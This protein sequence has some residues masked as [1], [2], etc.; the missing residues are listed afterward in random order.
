[1]EL[2]YNTS[3]KIAKRA[4]RLLSE[5]SINKTPLGKF[6]QFTL[7]IS[8][9]FITLSLLMLM[10]GA[11]KV[12]SAFPF[13]VVCL[14]VFICSIA[15]YLVVRW[16]VNKKVI[17]K[18]GLQNSKIKYVILSN[19]IV[20]YTDNGLKLELTENDIRRFIDYKE[21]LFMLVRDNFAYYIPP[22]AFAD[23]NQRETAKNMIQTIVNNRA[24]N[25]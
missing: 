24:A 7:A 20:H 9:V 14:A 12:Y 13:Y 22:I 17:K 15:F 5:I 21:Y 16:L 10:L 1:M 8:G 19:K 6:Y 4:R 18:S 3:M 11:N 23:S 25:K 2:E